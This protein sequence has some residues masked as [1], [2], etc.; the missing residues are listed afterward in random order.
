MGGRSCRHRFWRK[1]IKT[2]SMLVAVLDS[3]V[4]ENAIGGSRPSQKPLREPVPS[5]PAR[6]D[7]RGAI[8]AVCRLP[9]LYGDRHVQA[10]ADR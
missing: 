5:G 8:S 9:A 3:R 4:E 7:G 6:L 2:I 10:E 1:N